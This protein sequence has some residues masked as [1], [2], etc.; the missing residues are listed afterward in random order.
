MVG[1][2]LAPSPLL[3]EIEAEQSRL[4]V[5]T[6]KVNPE[7]RTR[8]VIPQKN[9]IHA[10]DAVVASLDPLAHRIESGTVMI[11][12]KEDMDA[13]AI[14]LE[15]D[16]I[17]DALDAQLF[18]VESLQELRAKVDQATPE[19]RYIL[20]LTENLYEIVPQSA[21]IRTGTRQLLEKAEG[22]PD[23]AEVKRQVKQFGEKVQK[24]TGEEGYVATARQLENAIDRGG[25]GA[26]S[27]D[28]LDDLVADTE[29]LQTLTE[30]LA[31][32][33][34]PPPFGLELPE[35]EP[36]VLLLE[37]VLGLAAHHNDLS[38]KAQTATPEQLPDFASR[39]RELESQ[40]A[41][42]IPASESHPNLIAAHLHLSEAVAKLEAADRVA[43][44]TSQH[45]AGEVLRYFVLEYALR[46]VVPLLG[47]SSGL[48]GP[49]AEDAEPEEA[50]LEL[51]MPGALTG[52]KPKGGR[53]EW[54]VIGRRERAALNENFARE[55]PL[56]YRAILKDYYERL[57]Q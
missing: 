39:L 34:T 5:L 3:A 8:L 51:F 56:E 50:E 9:L 23:A 41:A 24:L 18:V 26:G 54:Q 36:E 7:G 17:E 47:G 49:P 40:C 4:S 19:Y 27:E 16:D 28:V 11:F 13:A 20:E 32:L 45:K 12:A 6:E 37:K 21:R 53:L 1:S 48:P 35:P 25:A 31:Y 14:G 15:T 2:A 22:A 43:A 29:A 38:R 44:A 55:L 46:Y 33:I 42:F 10:V 57:T 52:T 30:N